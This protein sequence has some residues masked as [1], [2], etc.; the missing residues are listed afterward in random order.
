M[1]SKKFTY[2]IKKGDDEIYLYFNIRKLFI[3]LLRPE[4][5]KKLKLLE[6]YSHIFINMIFLKCRYQDKTEKIIEDFLKNYKSDLFFDVP[7]NIV[8]AS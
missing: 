1:K 3:D 8:Y 4:N 7:N 6:M 5:T 2:N